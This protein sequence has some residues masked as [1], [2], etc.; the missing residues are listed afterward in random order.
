MLPFKLFHDFANF[1]GFPPFFATKVLKNIHIYKKIREKSL[2]YANFG[3]FPLF[4]CNLANP[5]Y[6]N[7]SKITFAFGNIVAMTD[8]LHH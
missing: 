3:G 7:I 6:V 2:F 4:F 1:G 5:K 8:A